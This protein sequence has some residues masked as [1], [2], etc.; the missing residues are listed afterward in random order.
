M[1]GHVVNKPGQAA[2]TREIHVRKEL[3]IAAH[4]MQGNG[5]EVK[6]LHIQQPALIF[7]E[8]GSK[9][10]RTDLGI[11]VQATAGQAILLGGNQ[12]LDFTNL[13]EAGKSYEARWLVFDAELL[14]DAYYRCRAEALKTTNQNHAPVRLIP[15]FRESLRSAYMHAWH[16]LVSGN[17]IPDAVARQRTL[18]VL[19]WLLEEGIVLRNPTLIDNVTRKVRE[20]ITQSLDF[21][22]TAERIASQLALSEATLRRRLA[23][24]GNTLTDLLVDT[25]MATAL[26]LLQATTQPVSAIALS[27]GYESSSRFAIRFRQRFGFAPTSVRGHHRAG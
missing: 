23:A 11:C 16:A 2:A 12:T 6:R 8:R 27:V 20:V 22:W 9:S 18:E 5:L 7:V 1:T 15:E 10:V 26:T 17:G 19:H 25:R 24:E 14:E 4:V 13:L 21:A 3:G